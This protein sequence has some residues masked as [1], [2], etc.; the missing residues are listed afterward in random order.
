MATT[1]AAA[2]AAD[3]ATEY[4]VPKTDE[5][6]AALQKALATA[7][8][9]KL[10]AV[11]D[12]LQGDVGTAFRE[13]LAELQALK[14]PMGSSAK[15]NVDMM[16]TNLATMETAINGEIA[17]ADQVINPIE[18]APD[19]KPVPLLQMGMTRPT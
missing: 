11:R 3:A 8:K 14:L 10:E 19:P 18:N 16:L 2:T 12:G 15:A 4:P 7:H 1:K 13:K 9:R 5:Q 17:A 6:E